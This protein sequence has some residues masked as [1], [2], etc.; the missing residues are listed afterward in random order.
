MLPPLGVLKMFFTVS[1]EHPDRTIGRGVAN[2]L[3]NFVHP[4]MI[5]THRCAAN[6]S[7]AINAQVADIDRP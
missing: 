6:T 2:P 3:I 5:L 7:V 1:W 4:A